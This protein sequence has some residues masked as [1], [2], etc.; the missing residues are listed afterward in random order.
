MANKS[1]YT[2]SQIERKFDILEDNAFL[3]YIKG[4]GV[5]HTKTEIETYIAAYI[6]SH[7]IKVDESDIEIETPSADDLYNSF[8]FDEEDFYS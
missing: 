5:G 4:L 3:S 2:F 8:G 1:K 6:N 7:D